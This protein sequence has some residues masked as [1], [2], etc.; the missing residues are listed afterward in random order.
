MF[1]FVVDREK[2]LYN[3]RR[4]RWRDKRKRE[5]EE[6]RRKLPSSSSSS[7]SEAEASESEAEEWVTAD[8]GGDYVDR[9][10]DVA[11]LEPDPDPVP[12]DV[13][14]VGVLED[15]WNFPQDSATPLPPAAPAA[16]RMPTPEEML[17]DLVKT[18]ATIKVQS[19]VS[20]N[21][22][23]AVFRYCCENKDP[24]SYLLSTMR[25]TPSYKYS[26]RPQALALC[27]RI[28]CSYVVDKTAGGVTTQKERVGLDQIPNEVLHL[29][30]HGTWRL[31][32]LESYVSVAE[33]KKQHYNLHKDKISAEEM[34]KDFEN[35]QLSADGVRESNKGARTFTIVSIKFGSCIY[36][37]SVVNSLIGVAES[38]ASPSDL[39]G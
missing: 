30:N 37:L 19:D 39:L 14:I 2:R 33:V 5:L 36:V 9:V 13:R 7:S 4:K 22:L 17:F 34:K 18:M 25:I 27:P 10:E 32:R 35:A 31:L 11:R 23:D 24:I 29:S 26:I 21:A 28:L 6:E 15:R 20:D 12:R 8:G 1:K 3:E 38:K 16:P